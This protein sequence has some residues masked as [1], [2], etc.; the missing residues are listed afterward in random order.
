M[1]TVAHISIIGSHDPC[2]LAVPLEDPYCGL[3]IKGP[4]DQ[5]ANLNKSGE[6]ALSEIRGPKI[7]P[8]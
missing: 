3:M 8:K 4:L 6:T 1:L 7:D 2:V 5:G